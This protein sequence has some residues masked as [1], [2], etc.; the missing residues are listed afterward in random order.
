MCKLF[1]VFTRFSVG[2]VYLMYRA[3]ERVALFKPVTSRPANSERC[4]VSLFFFISFVRETVYIVAEKVTSGFYHYDVNSTK[5]VRK[6][7]CY[8]R[9]SISQD[10]WGD[11][12]E[13]WRSGGQK[14]PSGIQWQS[15]GRGSGGPPEAEAFFVK[16]HIIFAL[17]YNKQQLLLLLD[18]INLAAKYTF[19]NIFFTFKFSSTKMQQ[20]HHPFSWMIWTCFLVLNRVDIL[21]D[22]TSKILG[23]TLPRTSPLHKYSGDV[24]PVP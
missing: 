9:A 10:C 14:S 1:D 13:D 17:K 24:P 18:K 21:N 11:I 2:L 22:I 19:K 4:A 20:I 15:P 6:K 23:G 5:Y 12:K 3:F 8:A 16:L 7:Y